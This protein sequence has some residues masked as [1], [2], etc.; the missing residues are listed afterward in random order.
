[1]SR[2]SILP[3][4]PKETSLVVSHWKLRMVLVVEYWST[5]LNQHK[6]ISGP[7]S[8]L[9]SC[10]A[11]FYRVIH[12]KKKLA[13]TTGAWA[14]RGEQGVSREAL[15]E[16]KAQDK[17]RRKSPTMEKQTRS[18]KKLLIPFVTQYQ[19]ALPGLKRILMGKWHLIQNQ[20]GQKEI[21]KKTLIISYRKENLLSGIPP[22]HK[23]W[24][25]RP[26]Y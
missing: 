12:T 20:Q 5:R 8:S 9:L 26:L 6:P 14:K 21:F 22:P 25:V 24:L 1:M 13:C 18:C 15:N 23:N 4:S 7:V 3:I 11:E 19:Q 17:G 2:F 10:S 16:C